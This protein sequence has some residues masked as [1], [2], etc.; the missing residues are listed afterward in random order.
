[1]EYPEQHTFT[2]E[3]RIGLYTAA[4]LGSVVMSALVINSLPSDPK[5]EI[6][7]NVQQ[8]VP[9]IEHNNPT[10]HAG[11]VLSGV[12]KQDE[13]PSL[14]VEQSTLDFAEKYDVDL[15]QGQSSVNQQSAKDIEAAIH[16]VTGGSIQPGTT[17]E[18]R[19]DPESG[20]IV[21]THVADESK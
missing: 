12:I 7:N 4:A 20:Y 19:F 3:H 21:S 18:T 5:F 11:Q 1:M 13:I 15:K 10:E 2:K 8:Y 14:V 6:R 9:T 17:F 16:A